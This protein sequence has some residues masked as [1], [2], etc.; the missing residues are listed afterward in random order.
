MTAILTPECEL[1]GDRH[2]LF[3]CIANLLDNAVKYTPVGG[4]I[5]LTVSAE[6]T[7]IIITISDNGPGVP[8]EHRA[9]VIRR[10]FRLED[11]RTTPGNGLG[12]ALADAVVRR[13]DGELQLL[14]NR[15]GFKCRVILPGKLESLIDRTIP[16]DSPNGPRLPQ[17]SSALG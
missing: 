9:A 13:H 16:H 10:F 6:K 7:G 4:L 1:E 2:L 11:S 12:L 5:E 14:P 15:P 3:Q 17:L 8:D